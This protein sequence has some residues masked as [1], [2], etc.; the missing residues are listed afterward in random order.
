M[1]SPLYDLTVKSS[2]FLR[3]FLFWMFIDFPFNAVMLVA[4]PLAEIHDQSTSTVLT[5]INSWCI[6]SVFPPNT[7]NTQRIH[8][9]TKRVFFPL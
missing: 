4:A 6:F 7:H 3:T 1:P 8:N 5:Y 9:E 2:E